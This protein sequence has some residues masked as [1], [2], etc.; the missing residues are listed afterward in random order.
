MSMLEDRLERIKKIETDLK[1][2]CP[3]YEDLLRIAAC[4][5]DDCKFLERESKKWEEEFRSNERIRYYA[6]IPKMMKAMGKPFNVD[7]FME[8]ALDLDCMAIE[9][10]NILTKACSSASALK[11]ANAKHSRVGGSRDLADK[12]RKIWASG[13]YTSRDICAEQECSALNM[14]F[15]AARKALRNTPDPA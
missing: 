4:L 5:M 14:S 11:A 10:H 13:K 2:L 6:G 3:K 15:S 7:A 8:M 9:T 12:I 1:D